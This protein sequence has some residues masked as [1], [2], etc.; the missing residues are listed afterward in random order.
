MSSFSTLSVCAAAALSIFLSLPAFSQG[1]R[2]PEATGG[3]VL[4]ENKNVRAVRYAILPSSI[5]TLPIL[6]NDSL[7]VIL[8][9]D[10]QDVWSSANRAQSSRLGSG[11]LL[12]LRRDDENFVHN[13]SIQ[14]TR[15]L[16]IEFKDS[17]A[18]DQ[19]Q[20]PGS[21]RDPV[22]FDTR[23][24]RLV[25]ENQHARIFWMHLEPRET[26]EEVQFPLHVEIPFG[27]A[28]ISAFKPD[29]RFEI[30]HKEAGA[31]AWHR[32][33]LVS[34][35]NQEKQP[36]EELVVELRHPFCYKTSPD[37][38]SGSTP[39]IVDYAQRVY[40]K[41]RKQWYKR[42]PFSVGEGEQAVITVRIKIQAD[43]KTA[44]DDTFLAQVFA[45]NKL[46]ETALRAVREAAPFP[47][48]PPDWGKPQVDFG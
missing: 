41:V 13:I 10:A 37:M 25:L 22:N 8:D 16:V 40:R 45:G 15:I 19:I 42:L 31:I 39:V 46:T 36:F 29:G 12:W 35:S 5:V 6:K 4:L 48:I 11:E 7:L 2:A 23:H 38:P 30:E 43:G 32:N 20:V 34:I 27:A 18:V 44:D 26:T 21:L 1:V 3:E 47:A 9:G 33:R 28:Q 17:Y 24:F 14:P